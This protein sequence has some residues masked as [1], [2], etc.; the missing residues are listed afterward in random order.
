MMARFTFD[1]WGSRGQ[2]GAQRGGLRTV[3]LGRSQALP[4]LQRLAA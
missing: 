1:G 3:D 4:P 2:L